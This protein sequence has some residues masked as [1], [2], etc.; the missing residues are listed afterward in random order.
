MKISL[1]ATTKDFKRGKKLG[2]AAI[3]EGADTIT[4]EGGPQFESLFSYHPLLGEVNVASLRGE[5]AKQYVRAQG[6]RHWGLSL[7]PYV[8]GEGMDQPMTEE[9]IRKIVPPSLPNRLKRK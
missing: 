2:H 7:V 6:T 5:A 1:Y 4:V 9:E 3:A 8:S